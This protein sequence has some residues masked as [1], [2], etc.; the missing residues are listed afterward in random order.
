MAALSEAGWPD[1]AVEVTHVGLI[2]PLM[3]HPGGVPDAV[4]WAAYEVAFHGAC[5]CSMGGI[6]DWDEDGPCPASHP[7]WPC[8]I[9]DKG[10]ECAAGDCAHPDGP[11]WPPRALLVAP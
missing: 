5:E 6:C 3:P 7:C 9:T 10:T 1:A 4:W 11:R 8:W 2:T